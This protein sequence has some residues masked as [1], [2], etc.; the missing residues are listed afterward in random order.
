MKIARA[1]FIELKTPATQR[2]DDNGKYREQKDVGVP[3][4]ID[5]ILK[6]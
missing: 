6:Q 3:I 4:F 2:Y 5:E 1:A